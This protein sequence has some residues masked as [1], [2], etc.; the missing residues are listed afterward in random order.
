MEILTASIPRRLAE[1]DLS[2]SSN[3]VLR[4]ILGVPLSV[5]VWVE[6]RLV[7]L[8]EKYQALPLTSEN[9]KTLRQEL[10]NSGLRALLPEA[11]DIVGGVD[12]KNP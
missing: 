3:E 5:P 12:E 1:A 8:A 11:L 9:L 10:E 2:G 6:E 7:Q 4:E